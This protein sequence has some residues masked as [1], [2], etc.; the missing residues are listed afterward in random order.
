MHP[1][2]V[3]IF[4]FYC[5]CKEE[6]KSLENDATIESNAGKD[7]TK[8]KTFDFQSV[9]SFSSCEGLPYAPKGW[10]NHG[11][12]WGRKVGRRT[13]KAGYFHDRYLCLSRSLQSS[14]RKTRSFQSKLAVKWYIEPDFPNMKIEEFFALFSWKVPTTKRTRTKG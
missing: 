8:E 10:P 13:N 7:L 11:D 2:A 5:S 3:D 4:F 6:N 12:I 1:S 14:S 9:S